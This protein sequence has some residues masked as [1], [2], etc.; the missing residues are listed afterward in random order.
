VNTG[1]GGGGA[2]SSTGAVG[3]QGGSGIV[4]VRYAD[5]F[6]DAVT[7]TGTY[8]FTNSGGFKEYKFTDSGSI[9]W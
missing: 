5:T 2:R 9:K 3:G 6:A 7:V 4:I 1:G 8:T